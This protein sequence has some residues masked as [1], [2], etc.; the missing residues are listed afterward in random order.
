MILRRFIIA[1]KRIEAL[2][3][4]TRKLYWIINNYCSMFYGSF[5]YLSRILT[6]LY[7]IHQATAKLLTHKPTPAI[8]RR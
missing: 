6:K 2:M 1:L 5:L 8:S 3:T 4:I 7:N